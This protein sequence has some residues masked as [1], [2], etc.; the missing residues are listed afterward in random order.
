MEAK[1]KRQLTPEQLEKLKLAR[2]KAFQVRIQNKELKEFER[3]KAKDAKHYE[4]NKE[5]IDKEK[6]REEAVN[7][8]LEMKKKTEPVKEPVQEK[9][10]KPPPKPKPEPEPEPEEE[11]EEE[12]EYEPPPKKVIVKQPLPPPKQ[13][14]R[15]KVIQKKEPTD[16]E[17]YSSANIEMLKK[18]LRQQTLQ[19]LNADL[20]NY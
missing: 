6:K 18:K 16:D 5:K 19:R 9:K 15:K 11:S 13:I 3:Q 2:E 14:I 20:F 10:A 4:K 8:I 7:T 12:E 17:L 1:P